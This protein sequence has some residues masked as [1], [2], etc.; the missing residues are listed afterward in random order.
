MQNS[1]PI[2]SNLAT[3]GSFKARVWLTLA[4]P[5]CN[6]STQTTQSA[7]LTA[8]HF[9]LHEVLNEKNMHIKFVIMKVAHDK[10]DRHYER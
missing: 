1:V 9:R 10:C 8:E 5:K 3:L 2:S 4:L 6:D 7:T